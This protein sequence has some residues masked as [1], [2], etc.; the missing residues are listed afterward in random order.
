MDGV[1]YIISQHFCRKMYNSLV[2]MFSCV[3]LYGNFRTSRKSIRGDDWYAEEARGLL[4]TRLN[5]LIKSSTPML[6]T[7]PVKTQFSELMHVP[8]KSNAEFRNVSA[9]VKKEE[10]P[11]F[12]SRLHTEL[13][14][15]QKMWHLAAENVMARQ[16][17]KQVKHFNKRVFIISLLTNDVFLTLCRFFL[18]NFT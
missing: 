4:Q 16:K 11:S 1:C 18:L 5:K 7:V 9:K 3:I 13:Q 14:T 12:W 10:Q 17:V 6:V 15:T 2:T 8:V